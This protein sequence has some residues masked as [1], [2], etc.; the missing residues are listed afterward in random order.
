MFKSTSIGKKLGAHAI[1]KKINDMVDIC[2]PCK[3][4][5][6]PKATKKMN[7]KARSD[8]INSSIAIDLTEW[9]DKRK[10]TRVIISHI[11]D[12]F[13]RLS[14]A[15]IVETKNANTIIHIL[16]PPTGGP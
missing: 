4:T 3:K 8:K 1:K 14:S 7:E 2:I 13:S 10:R 9:F 12:E 11:V 15:K 5:E 16:Y 6:E